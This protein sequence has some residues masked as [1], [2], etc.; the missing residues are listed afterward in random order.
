MLDK[1]GSFVAISNYRQQLEIPLHG[2]HGMPWIMHI[3]PQPN[4]VNRGPNQACNFYPER[5]AILIPR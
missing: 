4:H 3:P 2:F 1:V 5:Y